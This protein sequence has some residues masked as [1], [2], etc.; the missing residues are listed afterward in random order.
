MDNM[1]IEQKAAMWDALMSCERIRVLGTG[2][3]GDPTCQHIGLELWAKYPIDSYPNGRSNHEFSKGRFLE[4]VKAMVAPEPE[5]FPSPIAVPEG[6]EVCPMCGRPKAKTAQDC[7]DG[8]CPKWYCTHDEAAE[9][10]CI[11][12][13]KMTVEKTQLSP[14]KMVLMEHVG[15]CMH[16][17]IP[18][19]LSETNQGLWEAFERGRKFERL[20]F[21][22]QEHF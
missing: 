15:A 20:S 5:L 16:C 8:M 10:D 17:E 7:A 18:K 11:R 4:F 22:E 6:Y 19:S 3:L 9:N 21:E 12:F 14:A 1:T 13:K 2:S